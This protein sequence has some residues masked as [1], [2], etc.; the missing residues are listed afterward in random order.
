MPSLTSLFDFRPRLYLLTFQPWKLCLFFKSSCLLLSLDLLQKYHIP[1]FLEGE[2]KHQ[3]CNV[4][5]KP[6]L[7]SMYKINLEI[8]TL[9]FSNWKNSFAHNCVKCMLMNFTVKA[10]VITCTLR[11][12]TCTSKQYESLSK[13][14]VI[15]N[16]VNV[17]RDLSFVM[18]LS[19]L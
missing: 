12:T 6:K 19:E 2:A 18:L 5:I 8:I 4:C 10:M 9:I 11:M 1:V 17:I 14:H 15:L 13:M 3:L 16:K 7:N